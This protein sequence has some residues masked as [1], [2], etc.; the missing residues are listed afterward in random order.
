MLKLSDNF[1]SFTE[2]ASRVKFHG[3][4]ILSFSDI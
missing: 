1:G 4:E 2:A 3:V